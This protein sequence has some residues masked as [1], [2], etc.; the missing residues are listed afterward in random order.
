MIYFVTKP[1]SFLDESKAMHWG[2]I[3]TGKQE[4]EEFP[5][6]E[7]FHWKIRAI[8]D[9]WKSTNGLPKFLFFF[10]WF[11]FFTYVSSF[12]SHHM[13]LIQVRYKQMRDF[14]IFWTWE[15]LRVIKTAKKTFSWQETLQVFWLFITSLNK[16]KKSSH[17]CDLRLTKSNAWLI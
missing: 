1:I 2:L 17:K 13:P 14:F 5:T 8:L 6:A 3:F 12:T 9:S 4:R 10:F 7:S 11:R 15:I 16:N